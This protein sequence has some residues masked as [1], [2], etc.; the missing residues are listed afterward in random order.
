MP[1][2]AGW[3]LAP[4]VLLFLAFMVLPLLMLGLIAFNPSVRGTIAL[5]PV[6]TLDNFTK[7]FTS[8]IYYKSLITSLKLGFL[9]VIACIVLGYPLAF[10]MARVDKGVFTLLSVLVLASMQ[11]D[12]TVRLYGMI[13]LF[14][15]S[16]GLLNQLLAALGLPALQ[17]VYNETGVVLGMVQF[18]LPFM[19][20]S[21]VG[22]LINLNP[23][24]EQAA[25]SLG[26][27]RW[28]AFWTV[29]VPLSLPALIAG[30][31]IVF[32]LSIS[33]YIVPVLL[34]SSRVPTVATHLYQQISE[35]GI[36]QFGS[37]IALVLFLS[38]LL[39][40]A[41][42]FRVAQRYAGVRV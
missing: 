8:P 17:L 27:S 42:S 20:F 15:N 24:Y 3:L 18:T 22:V 7:F 37:A 32:S 26:A 11:L 13:T 21:L 5:E 25:R 23:S 16:N 40:I 36:W 19:V 38:S 1:N 14:G 4:A 2:H 12:M 6:F 30:S 39:A 35:M 28:Y 10:I 41:L 29:T 34:G 31:V 33:S 9:T